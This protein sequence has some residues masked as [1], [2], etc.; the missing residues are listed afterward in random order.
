MSKGGNTDLC[1]FCGAGL[2]R[3]SASGLSTHLCP[4]CQAPQPLR[5]DESYF[6]LLGVP[7]KFHQDANLI[8]KRF[9]ELSRL[10]HPDRFSA[11]GNSRYQAYSLDRMSEINQAYQTLRKPELL[12]EYILDEHTGDNHAPPPPKAQIPMELAEE[13]FEIQDLVMDDAEAAIRR[14]E[15]LKD[16][17]RDRA[18]GFATRLQTE[19]DRFDRGDEKPAIEAMKKLRQDA[20]YIASMRR[21]I[22]R[23]ESKM[24]GA[25]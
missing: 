18:A 20:A 4:K 11:A 14:L 3:A 25:E 6:T 22:D 5:A 23:L 19:K 10:L 16:T 13:W 1:E 21:D 9:Y 2:E 24:R 8:Q 15:A 7:R 12:L 17:L